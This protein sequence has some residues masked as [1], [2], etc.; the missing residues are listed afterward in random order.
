MPVCCKP[1]QL[2]PHGHSVVQLCHVLSMLLSINTETLQRQ[3]SSVFSTRTQRGSTAGAC[4]MKELSLALLGLPGCIEPVTSW[5]MSIRDWLSTDS[6]N[7]GFTHHMQVHVKGRGTNNIVRTTNEIIHMI[8]DETAIPSGEFSYSDSRKWYFTRRSIFYVFI[9][10]LLMNT[11]WAHD[12]HKKFTGYVCQNRDKG[13]E[14]DEVYLTEI[15]C[16]LHNQGTCLP[17]CEFLL[18]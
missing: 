3:K 17:M 15:L 10:C 18:S 5:V 13:E 7:S 11:L 12:A 2:Q 14:S 6:V 4:T 8:W 1:S 16:L 9:F